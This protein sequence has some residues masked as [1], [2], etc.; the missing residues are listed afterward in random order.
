[1]VTK[2]KIF[3]IVEKNIEGSDIFLVN[4]SVGSS[5]TIKVYIDSNVGVTIKDCT[6][7]HKQIVN[8][9]EIIDEYFELQVSSPG[10][11]SSF[12]VYKQ[13]LKNLGKEIEVT[14]NDGI[15]TKGLLHTTNEQDIEV[16]EQV[17]QKKGNKKIENINSITIGLKNIKSAKLI[18]C[19]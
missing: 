10:I 1:M 17:Q 16:I 2:D 5:N 19:F 18:L 7:L 9:S 11:N 15:K 3:T 14:T 12:K 8:D 6:K 13:Y 4:V